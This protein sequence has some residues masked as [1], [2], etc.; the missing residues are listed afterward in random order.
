MVKNNNQL[1]INNI[2]K[3]TIKYLIKINFHVNFNKLTSEHRLN[4]LF[5]G[6][7]N[8]LYVYNVNKLIWILK[9]FF[10]NLINLFKTRQNILIISNINI[11][12]FDNLLDNSIY[13]KNN[14]NLKYYL[15]IISS[16]NNVWYNG[17]IS[18]WKVVYQLINKIFFSKKER[19][20][21]ER[22]TKL[23]KILNSFEH[24]HYVPFIPDFI[25]FLDINKKW[26]KETLR[27]NIPVLGLISNN[28]Y[29]IN[30]FLY[31]IIGNTNSLYS[32]EFLFSLIELSILKSIYL[33]QKLFKLYII[34]KIISK[35]KNTVV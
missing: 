35:I 24:R 7:V 23:K 8:N 30:S 15:N 22:Y 34:K 26:L 6:S 2:N 32:F 28:I 11:N 29:N 25:L 16:I 1:T 10:F 5:K 31:Y 3:L 21:S 12:K 20:K 33:E 14:I 17:L 4:Y 19:Y 9:Y 13:H 18:N 27:L